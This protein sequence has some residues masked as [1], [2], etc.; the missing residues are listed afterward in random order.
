MY[1]LKLPAGSRCRGRGGGAFAP[2]YAP[3]TRMNHIVDACLGVF[4]KTVEVAI[5]VEPV[6]V[7]QFL[8]RR[9]DAAATFSPARVA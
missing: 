5:I 2:R 4:D 1:F 7:E 3:L 6:R 9:A 8:F